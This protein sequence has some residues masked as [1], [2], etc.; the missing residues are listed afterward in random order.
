MQILGHVEL[1]RVKKKMGPLMNIREEP[2]HQICSL[3]CADNYWIMSRPQMHLEQMVV[4]MIEE[5][6]RWDLE[7][8]PASLW[9]TSTYCAAENPF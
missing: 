2:A 3:M 4:G 9:W 6:E 1:E 8:K 7:P 5:A